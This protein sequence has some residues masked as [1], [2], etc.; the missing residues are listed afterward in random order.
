LR[1]TWRVAGALG[2]WLVLE[3]YGATSEVSWL[4]L[5]AAW[6]LALMVAA[7]AYAAW[8]R[9][10][11]RL[12]LGVDSSRPHPDSP[13]YELPEQMLRTSPFPAPVFERDNLALTV[14]L[15]TTGAARGPAWVTG[16]VGGRD[17]RFGTGLVPRAGWTRVKV[18]PEVAR[19]PVGATGWAVGTSD[20]VGFFRG[21]RSSPDAEVALV[22][23][24][25]MPLAGHREARELE[26]A[27]AVPRAGSG[28][29]LFGIRE[30]RPGDS[31]R[32][33]HWRSSARH[34]ELVVREYEPPGLQ[35]LTILVDPAPPAREVADQVARIAASEAWDCI[36]EGGRVVIVS[37]GL[38]SSGPSRDMWSHLEWLARYPFLPS[39]G[40][41]ASGQSELVLIT[42]TNDDHLFDEA[43]R[44][45]RR[46]VWVVGDASVTTEIAFERVGLEWPL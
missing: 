27:M 17:I 33:I 2:L 31:L 43:E 13:L 19:G 40:F 29:E 15:R 7:G 5:L 46:R 45:R 35:T 28:N 12:T 1:P 41:A 26:A 21:R 20:P 14:G 37:P 25:F 44:A 32:R 4:F 36:R 23:P 24:R 10:G 11:L 8:N 38:E 22:L 9:A 30:F 42:A 3:W 6:I 18:L 16:K 39:G 34:G